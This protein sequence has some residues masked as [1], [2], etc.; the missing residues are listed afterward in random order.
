MKA[1]HLKF[2]SP[3]EGEVGPQVRVGGMAPPSPKYP[4][5]GTITPHPAP[6][7]DLPLKGGGAK[8]YAV[9]EGPTL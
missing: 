4:T 5:C 8:K 3:L 2:A 7:A 9:G 6:C 1:P